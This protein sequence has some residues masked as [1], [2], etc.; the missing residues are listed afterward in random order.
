[1]MLAHQR[2][3]MNTPALTLAERFNID[4]R[5]WFSK[6]RA[7]AHRRAV[8]ARAIESDLQAVPAEAFVRDALQARA[9]GEA[10][11]FGACDR[12][13]IHRDARAPRDRR[14]G[15]RDACAVRGRVR[16][17]PRLLR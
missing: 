12:S 10:A 1:M 5:T 8:Q 13:R 14:T 4:S 7:P 16:D 3:D 11:G 17:R 2:L 6:P 9:G 15:P